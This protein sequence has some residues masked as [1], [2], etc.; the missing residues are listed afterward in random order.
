[1]AVLDD[2]SSIRPELTYVIDVATRSICAIALRP[3]GTK[4]VD[5]ALL[6]ARMLVPAPLRPGWPAALGMAKSV[7]PHAELTE[8]DPRLGEAAGR[9]VIAP[10]TIVCDHRK[11]FI[12]TTFTAACAKLEISLQPARK[13]T[14]TDKQLASHCAPCG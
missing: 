6:L 8:I 14:P 1:M 9:P 11:V 3:A 12:S 10:E 2:R 7:L 5:A 13:D 4:G